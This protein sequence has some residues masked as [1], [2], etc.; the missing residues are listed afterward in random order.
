MVYFYGTHGWYINY[1]HFREALAK[2]T[3]TYFYPSPKNPP[4]KDYDAKA[5]VDQHNAD[6]IVVGVNNETF[7]SVKNLDKVKVPKIMFSDDPHNWIGPKANFMDVNKVDVM[8]MMNIGNWHGKPEEYPVFWREP[9]SLSSPRDPKIYGGMIPIADKY[10]RL[11]THK[12]KFIFFPESVNTEFFYDRGIN[13]NCDVFNSGSFDPSI[14]PLRRKIWQALSRRSNIKSCFNIG[15]SLSWQEYTKRMARSKMLVEGIGV[16]G[17]TCQRFTQAMASKTL[18]VS[19]LP[20][21]N[22]ENHFVSNETFVEI[23]NRNFES[24]VQYYLKHD[25]E[26]RQIVENAFKCV[27]QYHT[28]KIRAQQLVDIINE[29]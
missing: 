18:V 2:I 19:S 9:F 21:D 8:L 5:L 27:S 20:Y 4:Y 10:K 11:M 14:Y 3:T 15:L 23:N 12:P 22:L 17:Y 16:F 7:L 24:K 1:T 13:R 25:G 26:R 28:S 29:L 6:A